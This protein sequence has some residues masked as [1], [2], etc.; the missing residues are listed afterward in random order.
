MVTVH[1]SRD[2]VKKGRESPREAGMKVLL[3]S[4]VLFAVLY[5]CATA[6]YDNESYSSGYYVH[7]PEPFYY[8]EQYNYPYGYYSPPLYYFPDKYRHGG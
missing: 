8:D 2:N 4:A 5:G 3:L 6:R 1:D 7:E